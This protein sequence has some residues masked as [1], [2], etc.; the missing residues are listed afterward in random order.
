MAEVVIELIKATKTND[1]IIFVNEIKTEE[2]LVYGDESRI[3]QIL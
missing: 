1:N 2:A 3:E